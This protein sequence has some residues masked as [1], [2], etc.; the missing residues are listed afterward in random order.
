MSEMVS[1]GKLSAVVWPTYLGVSYANGNEPWHYEDYNR[2]QIFWETDSK[3]EPV[4]R[5]K[6]PIYVP[7]GEFT[8]LV[9]TYHPISLVILSRLRFDHPYNHPFPAVIDV[10]GITKEDFTIKAEMPF[11]SLLNALR[12]LG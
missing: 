8:H 5:N 4:G 9:F 2:S 7:R 6:T 12:Q 3:G 11:N 10:G 1:F